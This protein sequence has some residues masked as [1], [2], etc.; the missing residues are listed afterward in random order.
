[1]GNMNDEINAVVVDYNNVYVAGFQTLGDG[2][3]QWVIGKY[4]LNGNEAT[5]FG[6]DGDGYIRSDFTP[7]QRDS[8]NYIT[9]SGNF[10]YIA[11]FD[12]N[13]T[14]NYKQ[15][16]ILKMVKYNGAY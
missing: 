2:D 4:D 14:G 12:S 1:M 9:E 11:G 5:T 15:W 16:R 3:E 10:L 7:G 6:S 8:A 13:T